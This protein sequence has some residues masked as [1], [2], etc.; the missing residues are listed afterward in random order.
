MFLMSMLSSLFPAKLWTAHSALC[1]TASMSE[2]QTCPQRILSK[3][4]GCYF[5]PQSLLIRVNHLNICVK[6]SYTG[7]TRNQLPPKPLVLVSVAISSTKHGLTYCKSSV[8]PFDSTWAK[9]FI[10]LFHSTVIN[11]IYIV[12][13]NLICDYTARQLLTKSAVHE[14]YNKS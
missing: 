9:C 13:I 11:F 1:T 14:A 8:F 12:I 5:N 10:P 7:S 2:S 4:Y 6:E 3:Y